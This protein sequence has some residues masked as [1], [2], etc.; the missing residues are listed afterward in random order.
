MFANTS[1][2]IVKKELKYVSPPKDKT[3]SPQ[4]SSSQDDNLLLNEDIDF[5]DLDKFKG[6]AKGNEYKN[7][8]I[9]RLRNADKELYKD[10]NKSRKCQREH[11]P[12]V[13]SSDELN[14]LKKAG[15]EERLDN[16]IEYG[17]NKDNLNY[18]TCPRKW[19]PISKIPLDES[20][21]NAKCPGE[22]EEAMYLNQDM[23]NVNN[24][25]YAYLIKKNKFTLL[26]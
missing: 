26:W 25:R 22:N 1:K 7:Y 9:N 2:K 17:S 15:L 16:I 21:A 10:N 5:D 24:P 6:G 19:C 3:K 4:K 13:L 20:D 23:K 11:Q 14:E 8:L 12:V 18:Y